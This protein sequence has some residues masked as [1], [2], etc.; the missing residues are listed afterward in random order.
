MN[1]QGILKG[2]LY[3]YLSIETEGEVGEVAGEGEGPRPLEG[4]N[5]AILMRVEIQQRLA[6]VDD[7]VPHWRP[8][9]DSP[10]EVA[11]QCI[12]VCIIHPCP[13][14]TITTA[15]ARL[16]RNAQNTNL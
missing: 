10:Y 3:S 9:R 11:E 5:S 15:S 6:A 12:G 4:G 8:L 1:V 13:A 2:I 14:V 16:L 7:E